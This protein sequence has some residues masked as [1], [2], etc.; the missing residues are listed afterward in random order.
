MLLLSPP[1]LSLFF[2]TTPSTTSDDDFY[3]AYL[4]S[5]SAESV[6]GSGLGR[7]SGMRLFSW[8]EEANPTQKIS[9]MNDRNRRRM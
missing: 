9:A 8:Q 5:H 2:T 4:D 7:S 3:T 6:S 1:Q